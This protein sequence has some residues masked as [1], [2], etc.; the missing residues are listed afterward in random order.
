MFWNINQDFERT[1]K[2][3]FGVI[4]RHRISRVSIKRCKTSTIPRECREIAAWGRERCPRR[5]GVV[6][7]GDG[8]G[9][10]GGRCRGT[11]E[12]DNAHK[13]SIKAGARPSWR[14]SRYAVGPAFAARGSLGG[15]ADNLQTCGNSTY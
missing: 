14:S 4:Q 2:K 7:R 15:W 9:G 3:V 10:G 13:K 5:E 6:A 8:E 11:N 1:S 12:M